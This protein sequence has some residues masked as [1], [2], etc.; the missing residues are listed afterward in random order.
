MSVDTTGVDVPQI[1]RFTLEA[2]KWMEGAKLGNIIAR[3]SAPNTEEG[4]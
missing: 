4:Q 3:V 2:Q 1:S